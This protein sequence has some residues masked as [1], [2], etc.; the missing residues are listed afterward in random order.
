MNIEKYLVLNK[1]IISLFGVT[2]FRDLQGKL[3][4]YFINILRSSF[5]NL[6]L[7]EDTLLRYDENIQSYVRKI[8]YRREPI[9]L[10]YFQYLA[11]LFAEIILD[12]LKNRKIEF[13]YDLN[14]FLENYKREENIKLIDEFT[15]NDLKKLAFWMATGSG[16]IIL[17]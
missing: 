15:E 2:C 12:N 9:T 14:E 10:K 11:E 16:K 13:L 5:E 8:N 4:S 7:P 6:K 17:S 1:Y 3:R